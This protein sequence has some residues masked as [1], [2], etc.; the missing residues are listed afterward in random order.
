[1]GHGRAIEDFAGVL[2]VGDLLLRERIA[3]DVFGHRH[4]TVAVISGNPV[5]GMHAE[6]AVA[7]VHQFFDELPVYF[8]RIIT[9]L[10]I[11]IISL[12]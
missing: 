12:C 9:R 10:I 7:P 11:Y 3:Q 5:A 2:E 6:A 4:L 1:M 8:F